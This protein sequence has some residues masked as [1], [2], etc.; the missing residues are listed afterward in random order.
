M[1]KFKNDCYL[2]NKVAG[3]ALQVTHSDLSEQFKLIVE[4]LKETCDGLATNNPEEVL[5]GTIDVLVTTFGLLQKL[6]NLGVDVNKAMFKT[7]DNNLSKFPQSE[8]IAIDTVQMYES[9]DVTV[10]VEYYSEFDRFV[11]KDENGKVK[12]PVGFISND[13]KDCLPEELQ[14]TFSDWKPIPYSLELKYE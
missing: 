12:K 8:S 2:F 14:T 3:K 6:E 1:E 5:D 4:E 9:Q 11:I 7:A 13:L 10:T